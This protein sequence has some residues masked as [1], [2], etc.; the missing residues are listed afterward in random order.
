MHLLQAGCLCPMLGCAN[1]LLL[2]LQ[3]FSWGCSI[4]NLQCADSAVLSLYLAPG[5]CY[6]CNNSLYTYCIRN[7]DICYETFQIFIN[8]VRATFIEKCLLWPGFR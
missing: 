4:I 5:Y 7:Q 2:E 3:H 1:K 8:S 6:N